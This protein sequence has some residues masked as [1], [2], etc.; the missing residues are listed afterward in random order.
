MILNYI[1]VSHLLELQVTIAKM[2]DNNVFPYAKI[3]KLTL[4]YANDQL[5]SIDLDK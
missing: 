1:Y 3:G 2:K 4:M 5:C